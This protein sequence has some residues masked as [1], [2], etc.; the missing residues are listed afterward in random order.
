MKGLRHGTGTFKSESNGIDY[1]G[2][3]KNGLKH[4]YGRLT[5][6]SGSYY[7]GYFENGFKHG[8]GTMKFTSGNYY[9][10]FYKFDKKSGYGE[11]HWLDKNEVYKGF[12]EKDKQNG[13]GEH[14][15]LEKS[16]K[17]K[18]LR[19]R[20]QGMFF[21]GMRHGYGIFF[22]SDGTRYEGEWNNNL[23]QGFA[24]FTDTN[25][26]VTE[27]IF[28]EDRLLKQLNPPRQYDIIQFVQNDTQ[29]DSS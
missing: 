17:S 6:K 21:E 28:K 10:G 26:E 12:W 20:Y 8:K 2:E 24:L 14:I 7:E 23:K 16:S 4:G 22:Y 9:E 11:M 19:N 25:G 15:W 5:Y 29:E 27:A 18:S 13:F 1:D 3:W